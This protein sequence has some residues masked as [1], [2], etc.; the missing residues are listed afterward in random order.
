MVIKPILFS[1]N[2]VNIAVYGI[3]HIKDLRLHDQF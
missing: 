1:K 3:G 2:D